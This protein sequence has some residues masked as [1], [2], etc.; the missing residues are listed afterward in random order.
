M[1][2]N[3]G[4]RKSRDER[5]TRILVIALVGLMVLVVAVVA[6]AS[7][8]PYDNANP[9]VETAEQ[10]ALEP[11]PIDA[12]LQP[13]PTHSAEPTPTPTP[14]PAPTLAAVPAPK[15]PKPAKTLPEK[16]A[17]LPSD[18]K[19]IVIITGAKIGSSSGTLAVYNKV[20]GH[21]VGVMAEV[22]AN[23]GKNGLIDGEKRREG[24]LETPTGIWTVGDFLF[25]L[26]PSAPSGTQMPYR[27]ITN[28]SYWSG[29]RDSTYNT[30]VNH[31]VSG[32]HLIDADP[33]YEY[34]FNTGYNSLPNERVMGRGTAIF[35]HCFE[36]P[37]NAL[38]RYTHGCIAIDR[39]NMVRLFNI[40]DPAKKP[41]CAIGTL[42]E[43][44]ATSIWAY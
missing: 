34:A 27:P 36:P 17:H 42:Q 11:T 2:N 24:N 14:T 25:G 6:M 41:V 19:Q 22:T 40:L 37:D 35:I 3:R 26:H 43:G 9:K 8:K 10:P 32:E 29:Q 33:Q 39:D 4:T 15:A 23:F 21:W 1:T 18:T 31:Q 16:M 20:N 30:W 12:T 5:S 13:E 28:S 7:L 44:T 38:G